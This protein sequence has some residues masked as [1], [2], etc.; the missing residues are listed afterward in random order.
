MIRSDRILGLVTVVAALAYIV[1][2]AQLQTSFLSDP[3]GSK[4]FPYIVGGITMICGLVFLVR[5]D[6]DPDWAGAKTWARLGAA[7]VVLVL[8]AYALKPLGF[9]LPTALA[10]AILSYQISPRPVPA[11][12]TGLGLS[13]GLFILFKFVL[14]LG[15]V[16]VPR[17]LTGV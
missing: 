17:G 8:Y 10:A 14:G 6:P 11:V 4:T 1:S 15:L 7:A 12:I 16:A 2:A 3:V 9:L 13:A 5:P